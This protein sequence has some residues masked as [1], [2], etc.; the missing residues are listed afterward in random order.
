MSIKQAVIS[1]AGISSRFLPIV[2]TI[3]K[4]FLPIGNKPIIHYLVEECAEAGVEKVIIVAREETKTFF[5]D[6]FHNSCD[7]LEELLKNMNKLNRF[8]SVKN[9]FDLP[10]VQVITQDLDLPYGTA[11]PVISARS[12]LTEEEPFLFLHADDL[13]IADNKDCKVLVDEYEENSDYAGYM[14]TEEIS[15]ERVHLYGMVKTKGQNKDQLDRIVEKPTQK[16]T[17]S[18]LASYGRFLYK[19]KIFEY[20]DIDRLGKDN[21]LWNVDALTAM[22]QEYPVKVVKNKGTWVTTGDPLNYFKAQI[23][24]SRTKKKYSEILDKPS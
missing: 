15:L 10:K 21:E 17:P 18:L 23:L 14:I 12:Y 24:F 22:A 11:A 8:K 1:D 6:Y 9:V 3:P 5:D 13:V 2:K 19:Y 7:E 4:S 20:L 16:D